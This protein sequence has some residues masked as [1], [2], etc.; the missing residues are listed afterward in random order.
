[1]STYFVDRNNQVIG[2]TDELPS[3]PQIGATVHMPFR[4]GKSASGV[5]SIPVEVLRV[6]YDHAATTVG[7]VHSV[8][9]HWNI[10][11]ILDCNIHDLLL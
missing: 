2:K 1:M 11:V 5:I 6:E 7:G 9:R 4:S 3:P 10:N 8:F